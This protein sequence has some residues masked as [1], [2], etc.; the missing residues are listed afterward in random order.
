[1]TASY[2]FEDTAAAAELQRLRAI[3]AVF[4]PATHRCLSATGTLIARR[5]L[6]VGAGA[7]SIARWLAAE[8]GPDGK[9][10]ALDRS[11]R[12]LEGVAAANVEVVEG[13]VL[14]AALPAEGFD[15][16]HARYVLIH[17]RDARA[18]LL[19]MWRCLEPGGWLILE[20]PDFSVVRALAG[21][22][23]LRRAFGRVGRAVEAMF[24][25][26]GMDHAF[27]SRLPAL[28]QDQALEL[29]AVENDAPIV[30]GGSGIAA[31]M[32]MSTEQLRAK[33]L[34][35]GEATEEDLERYTAFSA[36]PTC[37]AIHYATVRVTVRK[38]IP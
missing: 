15:L 24:A 5:C 36:D 9:V 26:G 16:V 30:N 17:N 38:P 22:E 25:A 20:E 2:V 6:E 3:E 18:V 14:T 19:A 28:V 12:F 1:M 8:A 33:Y 10:V 34:A 21:P 13:D 11:T 23:A 31:M 27:G 32:A 35:T 7:G 29:V 37:W 4:D